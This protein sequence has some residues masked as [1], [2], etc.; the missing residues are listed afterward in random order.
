[1]Q[2]DALP[3]LP[4]RLF[5]HEK[6]LSVPH[7]E[8]VK[9]MTSSGTS[10]QNTSQIFLA[11]YMLALQV[12]VLSRIVGDF[13]GPKRLPMLVIDCRATVADRY[14]FSAR[15]AGVMGFLFS[16]ATLNSL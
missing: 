8:V 5:K 12:K 10:G 13:I 7:T 11:R 9:T 3:F 16:G 4:V 1:M 15:T 2:L 6:L 14:R